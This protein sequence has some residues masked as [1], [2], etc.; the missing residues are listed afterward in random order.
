VR[1]L[2]LIGLIANAVSANAAIDFTPTV[3]PYVSEG[4]EYATVSFKDDKRSVSMTLPRQWSCRGDG[5]HLQFTPPKESL[6]EGAIQAVPTKGMLRFDEATVKSL[7]QQVLATLPPGSQAGTIVSAQENPVVIYQNLSYEFVLSY[8]A[9][10]Q[11]FQRSVIVVSCPDQILIFKFSAPKAAFDAL[12]RSFRQ[13]VC[14]WEWTEPAALVGPK[15][16]SK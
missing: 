5:S 13:S 4:A 2:L 7:E 6:A 11:L 9:L 10:G 15:T 3:T 8:K 14:S 1:R 16:A 12:N